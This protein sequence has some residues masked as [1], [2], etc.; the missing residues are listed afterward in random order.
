MKEKDVNETCVNTNLATTY[1]VFCCYVQCMNYCIII[2]TILTSNT[3]SSEIRERKKLLMI[4]N[5]EVCRDENKDM[6]KFV[7]HHI[8]QFKT[9]KNKTLNKYI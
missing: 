8:K 2:A 5:C 7:V 4:E 6:A 9:Q 1:I 3:T